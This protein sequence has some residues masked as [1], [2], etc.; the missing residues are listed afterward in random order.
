MHE[1]GSTYGSTRGQSLT[2]VGT[3]LTFIGQYASTGVDI[4]RHTNNTHT[5]GEELTYQ[6]YACSMEWNAPRK[7][8]AWYPH[9]LPQYRTPPF[10]CVASWWDRDALP[11]TRR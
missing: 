5:C 7:D 11:S 1:P 3:K 6:G 4:H 9:S 10:T 2:F 8:A